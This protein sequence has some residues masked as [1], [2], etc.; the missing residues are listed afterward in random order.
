MSAATKPVRVPS[1]RH[2]KPSGQAVVTLSGRDLYLG[3]WKSPDSK[4]EYKRLVA[5]WLASAGSPWPCRPGCTA[6][7]QE[8]AAAYWT[9]L[10]RTYA[11]TTLPSFKR[12][13]G[14]LRGLYADVSVEGFGPVQLKTVRDQLV[15]EGLARTTVNRH[16][17]QVRACFRWG[18]EEGMVAGGVYHALTAI[19]GLRRGRTDARETE[20]VGP[21]ADAVVDATLPHLMPTVVAMVEVQRLTGMRPGEVCAMTTGAIDTSGRVWLYKPDHHKTA[22]H[23]HSRVIALG[24]RAQAAISRHLRP[25]LSAPLFSPAESERERRAAA[26]GRRVTPDNAGNTIGTNRRRRPVRTP[27]D[28]WDTQA[29]GR[30]IGYG[31]R[32]AFPL[33][34]LLDRRDGETR[35]AWWARLSA[36]EHEA[37]KRWWREHSWA[38]NQLRHARATEVRRTFGLE[39]AAATLGHSK[40]E[41]TAEWY[42]ERSRELAERVALAIG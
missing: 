9:H 15:R 17:H 4:R 28:C 12:A 6:S 42:A 24:P 16:V 8:L 40:L 11:P 5:E 26:H 18:V 3:P 37:V 38:P 13:L 23:G 27:S 1:Y 7:V 25:D 39:G 19:R 32:R 14:A 29:Y 36:E 22:H 33:P 30:A 20:P 41:T 34:S 21:V 31:C 10:Q 35:A 2:H